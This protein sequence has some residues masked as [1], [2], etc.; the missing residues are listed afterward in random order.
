MEGNGRWKGE[1]NQYGFSMEAKASFRIPR[2]HCHWVKQITNLRRWLLQQA[3]FC[4]IMATGSSSSDL[5]AVKRYDLKLSWDGWGITEKTLMFPI[6]SNS[7]YN[8]WKVSS[9]LAMSICRCVA[10]SSCLPLSPFS[11]VYWFLTSKLPG[12][13]SKQVANAKGSH[14]CWAAGGVMFEKANLWEPKRVNFLGFTGRIYEPW[15]KVAILG[16]VIPPLIGNPYNNGYINPY[17][18]VDDHPLLYGNMM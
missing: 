6:D 7:I 16:M 9:K 10:M 1:K 11:H 3:P 14:E 4:R 18:W 13:C 5:D 2:F 12:N 15:S 17:Y 8:Y